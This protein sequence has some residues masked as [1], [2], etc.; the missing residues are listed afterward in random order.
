MVRVDVN[1]ES[2]NWPKERRGCCSAGKTSHFRAARG[3]WGEGIRAVCVAT[4]VYP[5]G[6]RK[7]F[8]PWTT[9]TLLSHGQVARKKWLVQPESETAK[10]TGGVTSM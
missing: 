1:P 7:R 5:F 4:M 3:S 9:A 6:M 10:Y 8:P 2:Q